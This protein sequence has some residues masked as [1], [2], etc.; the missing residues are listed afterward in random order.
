MPRDDATLLDVWRAGHL[1]VTFA[2]D[3]PD[4]A[5]LRRDVKTRSAVLHQ[6]LVMGEA[7]KRLSPAFRAAHPALP[8]R[9]MAGLRDVL[10]HAYDL[11]EEEEVWRVLQRE[12]PDVLARLDPLLPPDHTGVVL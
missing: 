10:I 2:R 6:L 12:L 8:W 9:Q 5:G 3:V 7:V 1:A 4:A 11:V